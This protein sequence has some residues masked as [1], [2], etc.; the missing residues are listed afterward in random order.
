MRRS[1]RLRKGDEF[2]TVYKKGAVISGPL[3]VVRCLGND[4]GHPRW[5][6]AVGKRLA[7]KAV[8]R[9]RVRRR[10]R[11]AVRS[12]CVTGSTDLV[13]TARVGAVKAEMIDLRAALRA[14]LARAGV[15]TGTQG[16]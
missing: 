10:L 8:V 7:P 15:V 4:L 13:V 3:L 16:P 12:L 2:D 14:A 9:N 1:E 11:E 5:G 6:F